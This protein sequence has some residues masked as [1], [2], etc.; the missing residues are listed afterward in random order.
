MSESRRNHAEPLTLW[1]WSKP[2]ESSHP[3]VVNP[4]RS[5]STS[6]CTASTTLSPPWNTR[7]RCSASSQTGSP[8]GL[9]VYAPTDAYASLCGAGLPRVDV[10]QDA[11]RRR[12][13]PGRATMKRETRPP[14]PPGRAN[15]PGAASPATPEA[16]PCNAWCWC[17]TSSGTASTH[18]TRSAWSSS[19]TPTVPNPTTSSSPPTAPPPEP[20]TASRYAG[21]WSIEVSFR[22]VQQD[23]GGHQP[24]AW[25]RKGPERAGRL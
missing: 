2:P 14:P 24:Q 23:L 21:P 13:L 9:F 11:P 19:A 17:A 16:T 12:P 1:S 6:A 15:K 5:R 8:A 3:G 22:D 4:S 10:N 18:M 7:P 20:R 25:K